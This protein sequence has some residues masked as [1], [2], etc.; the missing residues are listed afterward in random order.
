VPISLDH[1]YSS[2]N[3]V[4]AGPSEILTVSQE[5]EISSAGDKLNEEEWRTG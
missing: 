2:Y 4:S 3:D 5:F 1:G